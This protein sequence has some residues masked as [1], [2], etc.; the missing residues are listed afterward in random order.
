MPTYKYTGTAGND[1]KSGGNSGI[2]M[3]GVGW[4]HE[5]SYFEGLAGNDELRIY[6][7]MVLLV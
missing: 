2:Y 1:D 4:V 5:D 6:N 3:N 7:K